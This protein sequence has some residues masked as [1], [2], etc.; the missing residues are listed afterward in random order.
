MSI[1]KFSEYYLNSLIKDPYKDYIFDG[2]DKW[3]SDH[4]ATTSKGSFAIGIIDEHCVT[5]FRNYID[6]NILPEIFEII[7]K[8]QN[9]EIVFISSETNIENY[10][11]E[12]I[13]KKFPQKTFQIKKISNNI[14]KDIRIV[15]LENKIAITV[16]ESSKI[17]SIKNLVEYI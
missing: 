14:P 7:K 4:S 9:T 8:N 10:I 3:L 15:E 6:I 17:F 2:S 12:S 5:N 13:C 16:L 11:Y 1:P